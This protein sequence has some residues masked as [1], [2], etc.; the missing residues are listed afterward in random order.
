MR[1]PS[2]PLF[3]YPKYS[4][5]VSSRNG[6]GVVPT[7]ADSAQTETLPLVKLQ[8]QG[9]MQLQ[10][11]VTFLWLMVKYKYYKTNGQLHSEK[12][13]RSPL[14]ILDFNPKLQADI[15]KSSLTGEWENL[16]S[17]VE[18]WL[19][20]WSQTRSRLEESRGVLYPEMADRCRSVFEAQEQWDKF[21]AERDELM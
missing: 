17:T 20:R 14:E 13:R 18:G 6:W 21:V 10:Y 2:L 5:A 16:N 11:L 8:T 15:V 9:I 3:T 12:I 1:W 4:T 19:S 7:H